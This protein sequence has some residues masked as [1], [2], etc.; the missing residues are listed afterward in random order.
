M[1][2]TALDMKRLMYTVQPRGCFQQISKGPNSTQT[3]EAPAVWL[4]P[5]DK[6]I[7][8]SHWSNSW[9]SGITLEYW[10]RSY[11]LGPAKH[12][13]NSAQ[14]LLFREGDGPGLRDTH[15]V[16]PR[17]PG[18]WFLAQVSDFL[19]PPCSEPWPSPKL[20]FSWQIKGLFFWQ[21]HQALKRLKE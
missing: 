15:L 6:R 17:P 18:L 10:S 20:H 5:R 4:R 13:K 8:G 11:P 19:F 2:H 14:D 16:L 9:V 3:R 1:F 7:V 21:R 12:N